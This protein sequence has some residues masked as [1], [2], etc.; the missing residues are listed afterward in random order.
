MASHEP[1]K[2]QGG[3]GGGLETLLFTRVSVE[4]AVKRAK[5]EISDNFRQKPCNRTTIF[6]KRNGRTGQLQGMWFLCSCFFFTK[7]RAKGEILDTI[8]AKNPY[9][10][11]TIF[12]KR[13]GFFA[14]YIVFFLLFFDKK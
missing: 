6:I 5:D 9:N 10:R 12:L 1:P 11:T 3:G 8:A 14:G 7:K 2:H 4:V 13:N